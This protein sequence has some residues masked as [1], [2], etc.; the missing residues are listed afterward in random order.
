MGAGGKR[1]RRLE[2]GYDGEKAVANRG[3]VI[4]HKWFLQQALITHGRYPGLFF[5]ARIETK[6][7]FQESKE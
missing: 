4:Y 1:G 3:E 2:S 7:C 5:Q 6:G